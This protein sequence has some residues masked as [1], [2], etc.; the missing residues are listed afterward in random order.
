MIDFA[1]AGFT[2]EQISAA[3]KVDRWTANAGGEA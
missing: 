3:R 1:V 2:E